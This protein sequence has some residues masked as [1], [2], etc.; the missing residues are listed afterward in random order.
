M[1]YAIVKN[2]IVQNIV[3]AE[4]DTAFSAIFPDA[5]EFSMVT[6]ESGFPFIGLGAKL[7][8]FQQFAS[9]TFDES[10]GEWV[11]PEPKP[12]GEAYWD[13]STLSWIEIELSTVEEENA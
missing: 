11:A 12:E 10:L 13:E 3:E 6:P 5:D 8:K 9:W 4:R 1:I 7:G 2:S